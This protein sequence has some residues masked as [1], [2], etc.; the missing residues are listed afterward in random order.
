M[1]WM[2]EDNFSYYR[3]ILSCHKYE[4]VNCNIVILYYVMNCYCWPGFVG[5]GFMLLIMYIKGESP[6]LLF[7]TLRDHF[8]RFLCE[9]ASA[10]LYLVYA[11]LFLVLFLLVDTLGYLH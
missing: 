2:V 1:T 8:V 3:V 5:L 4:I 6:P 7:I 10:I 11:L 9:I